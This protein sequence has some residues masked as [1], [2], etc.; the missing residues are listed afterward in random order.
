M[1]MNKFVK[2]PLVLGVVGTICAGALGVVYEITNPIIQERILAESFASIRDLVPDMEDGEIV[3]DEFDKDALSAAGITTV[4]DIQKDNATYAYGYQAEVTGYK[5]GL[6][7]VVVFSSTEDKVIGIK[8]VANSETN[9]IGG[10]ALTNPEFIGQFND[11]SF[12]DIAS[13]DTVA[14]ATVTTSALKNGVDKIISFHKEQVKGE[15]SDGIN[16]SAGERLAFNLEE[17]QM[18]VDKSEDFLGKLRENTSENRYNTILKSM[19]LINFLEIQDASSNVLKYAYVVENSYSCELEHG[20]RGTQTYKLALLFDAN[21]SN[22]EIIVISSTDSMA[23]I[24]NNPMDSLA[25]NAWLENFEGKTTS[26]LLSLMSENGVDKI[27]GATFTSNT[28][29]SHITT[30]I[31]AHTRA[32]S[33]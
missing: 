29:I 2:F 5:P 8:I 26:E 22:S 13:A 15:E 11:A 7:F 18:L 30:I 23:S 19:K 10:A 12:D 28:V 31:D 33:E 32:Y 14:G 21:W 20:S 17:G 3:T 6:S 9:S 4:Y 16:L 27:A 25:S 24:P 1:N